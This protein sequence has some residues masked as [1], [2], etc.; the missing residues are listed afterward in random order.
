MERARQFYRTYPNASALRPQLNWTQ[1]KLL[2]SISD[3]NKREYYE[4]ESI[5][6]CWT[7]LQ[8]R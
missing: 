7:A 3:S 8:G 4:L 5:N 2:I 6:N 1:Y